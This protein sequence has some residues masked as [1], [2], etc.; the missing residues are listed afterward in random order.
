[1]SSFYENEKSNTVFI[2]ILHN[3]E[4]KSNELTTKAN[5]IKNELH[6]KSILIESEK[7][8][9]RKME[10][11][12]NTIELYPTKNEKNIYQEANTS[13]EL[14][15][16]QLKTS[17]FLKICE[18]PVWFNLRET[19]YCLLKEYGNLI[20]ITENPKNKSVIYVKYG[21]KKSVEKAFLEINT[22]D[23]LGVRLKASYYYN[24]LNEKCKEGYGYG[25]ILNSS[26][27]ISSYRFEK[28]SSSGSSSNNAN[29]R[30]Q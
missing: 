16:F 17:N 14:H 13:K 20:S 3:P 26:H 30:S 15:Q 5:Q 4:L 23:I 27:E 11:R 22:H 7:G 19:L 21:N 29:S 6:E 8:T 28:S 25:S 10:L 18:I 24:D 2:N 1:M 9:Q 12:K